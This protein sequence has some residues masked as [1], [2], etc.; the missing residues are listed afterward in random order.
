MNPLM[1]AMRLPKT[2]L[3]TSNILLTTDDAKIAVTPRDVVWTHRRT[4]LYRYRSSKRTHPIP[5]LL[6]FALINRPMIYDLRP[7]HSFVEYLL[8]R[9]FDVF[10]IDW[11][12]PESHDDDMG[13]DN[14]VC[15]ELTWAVREVK[16]A[17]GASEISIIGWCIGAVL[18]ALYASLNPGP[19]RNL[20]LLTMPIDTEGS[21]YRTWVGHDNFDVEQVTESLGNVPGAFVDWANKLMKP[22]QNHVTTKRK[23]FE[24]VH[25]GVANRTAYQAMSKWVGDNPPFAGRA[26]EQWITW[27][28]KENRLVRNRIELRGRRADLRNLDQSIL[29]VTAD[30]DH[31]APRDL[32]MPLLD[33]VS[34]DDLE[35]LDRAGGH[36]GLMAGS[37]ARKEIWPD[38]ADW[39]ESRSQND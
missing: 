36:I 22:V 32:T 7:G 15:D 27:M 18:T 13:I 17:T 11:G 21:L 23:L 5:V 10:L 6:V 25:D 26:Y 14:Y 24:Q 34:S 2:F 12:A 8:D 3:E 29:V 4:T 31:I 9:G 30:A 19:A 38:I 35:H 1:S 20:V 39:L 16:R 28:Y 33:M 37:K